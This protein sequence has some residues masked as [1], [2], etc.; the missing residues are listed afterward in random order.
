M[1]TVE[2]QTSAKFLELCRTPV[3]LRHLGVARDLDRG[4]VV[5]PQ[6]PH[7]EIADR[8]PAEVG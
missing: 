3:G 1:P 4:A 5:V 7:Q 8:V 6:Q 2:R